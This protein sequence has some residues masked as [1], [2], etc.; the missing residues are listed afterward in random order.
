MAALVYPPQLPCP[1]AAPITST[2][3]RA[4]SSLDGL[5]R[6]R[7]LWRDR[8]ATRTVQFAFTFAEVQ[9]FSAWVDDV[10]LLAGSWFAC[11]WRMPDGSTVSVCRFI[12]PPSYPEYLAGIGWRV[13]ADVEVRG[14]SMLPQAGSR[15]VDLDIDVIS[16]VGGTSAFGVTVSGFLAADA[17][18]FSLP[19]GRLHTGWSQYPADDA[20]GA[21]PLTWSNEFVVTKGPGPA[22]GPFDA[23]STLYGISAAYPDGPSARAGF[24][25]GSTTGATEYT[26]WLYDSVPN[27]DRGGLSI[28]VKVN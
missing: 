19:P 9:A 2:E 21:P 7:A 27:D 23:R 17:L 22:V 26:F 24:P 4:L 5:R 12:T 8:H 20:I 14:R 6:S 28:R 16:N 18:V 11:D 25:G 1:T 15:Y 3:R 10:L 13:T